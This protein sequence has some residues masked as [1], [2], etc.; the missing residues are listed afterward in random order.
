MTKNNCKNESRGAL[1]HLKYNCVK[2]T[3]NALELT[4]RQHTQLFFGSHPDI[5]NPNL[6]QY[7]EILSNLF[8]YYFHIWEL[9]HS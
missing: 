9:D 2:N 4:R 1:D 5:E 3:K 8:P 6:G 7:T